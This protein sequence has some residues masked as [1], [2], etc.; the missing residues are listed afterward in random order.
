MNV[1]DSDLLIGNL[2]RNPEAAI[3][4]ERLEG[5]QNAATAI[6]EMELWYG[7][8]QRTT[9]NFRTLE[10]TFS[11]LHRLPLDSESARKAGQIW[12]ELK[13]KGR[14]IDLR[15]LMIAA[16]AIRHDATL[17]SRN[18]RHFGRIPG[19]KVKRW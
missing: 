9:P 16:I 3:A 7:E 17:Y 18:L 11:I 5:Q 4:I 12:S 1:L 10:L 6:T 19:L 14:E 2:R 8:S 13:R 15:D